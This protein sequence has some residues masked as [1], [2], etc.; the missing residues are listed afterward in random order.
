MLMNKKNNKKRFKFS[1]E[2]M[3]HYTDDDR[4]IYIYKTFF[5]KIN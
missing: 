5:K 1:F 3:K 2:I 4:Q